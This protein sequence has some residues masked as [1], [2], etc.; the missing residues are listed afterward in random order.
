MFSLNTKFIRREKPSK[1]RLE[2]WEVEVQEV[3]EV[4]SLG[5]GEVVGWGGGSRLDGGREGY[6]AED[7]VD[8]RE[9]GVKEV[10]EREMTALLEMKE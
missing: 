10:E 2:V 6:G 5:D 9:A 8:G 7:L 1:C 4:G 3:V